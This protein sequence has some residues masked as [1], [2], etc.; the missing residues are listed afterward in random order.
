M[1]EKLQLLME[2]HAKATLVP[3]F[4]FEF[5]YSFFLKAVAHNVKLVKY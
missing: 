1:T 4:C 3:C 5:V 2:A